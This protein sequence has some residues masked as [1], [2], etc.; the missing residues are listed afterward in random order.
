MSPATSLVQGT[1]GNFYGMTGGGG[2]FDAGTVFKITPTG[3]LTVLHGFA[4]GPT[5]GSDPTAALVQATDGNFY[6]TT[7]AG[8]PADKGTVFKMTPA[9]IVTI[10]HFFDGTDGASPQG[11]LIQATDGNF[12]GTTSVGGAFRLGTVFSM[13]PTGTLTVLHHFAGGTDGANPYGRLL[14]A[15]DG[16]LYGTTTRGGSFSLHGFDWG[17]IGTV[18]KVTPAGALTILHTFTDSVATVDSD[19][20][21]PNG[22]LIQAADGNF[23]GTTLQNTVF[24]MTPTGVLTTL[25]FFS[26]DSGLYAGVI[27]AADGNFYG[28]LAAGNFGMEPPLGSVFRMTSDGDV[29][30]LHAFAFATS[31]MEG[32]T[33]RAALIQ[34]ADGNFYGTTTSGGTADKGTIFSITPAGVLTVLQSLSGGTDG[35]SPQA[36]LIVATDG[37]FYG[38]TNQGG[39]SNSGTAFKMTPCGSLTVLHTFSSVTD[40]GRPAALIQGSDGNFYGTTASGGSAGNGT[41]FRMTAAG[42]VTV[43]HAFTGG[44]MDGAVP[45]AALIQ[46]RDGNFYGTTTSGGATDQG[47]VFRMTPAGTVTVLH[48]FIGGTAD[49]ASPLAALLQGADGN[50]YGTTFTGGTFNGGAV[51]KITPAGTITILHAFAIGTTD[52]WNPTA[53]LVQAT[54]GNFYGTT[55]SGGAA[56]QGTVFTM[57]PD[58]T[59][60]ILHSFAGSGGM[61]GSY[62]YGGLVQASDGNFYGTTTYGGVSDNGTI[63]K[64]TRGG[65]YS[66]LRFLDAGKMDGVN[67]LSALLQGVDGNLYGTASSG[68]AFGWGVVFRLVVPLPPSIRMNPAS[69]TVTLGQNPQFTVAANGTPA[70]TYQW[71]V[72]TTGGS[73]WANLSDAVPYSGVTTTTLT[74]T[75]ATLGLTGNQYR[76]VATNASG[77]ATSAVATLTV[78]PAARGDFDRDGKADIA[79]YRAASG[80]WY[81]LRS[82]SGYTAYG[83]QWGAST[84][85]PVPGDYDGDGETDIAI[86]RPATGIWYVLLSST[87]FAS[88]LAYQWGVSTD[89]PVPGDY[90]G[91]GK[92]DVAVYRPSTGTWYVLLSSTSSTTYVAYQWGVSTDVPVSADYDGD[93]KTDV[94]VYRPTTG[95]WY[96]LLSRTNAATY[97]AYQWGINSDIPVPADYD[98]DRKADIA[99]YRPATGIWYLLRSS[100]NSTT[101]VAYQ[102]GVSA[103]VPVPADF[104]GDGKTDIA[105]FRP[106][107]GFW[108]ILLSS[109]NSATYASYQWGAASDIPVLNRR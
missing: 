92:T 54:D 60:T 56:D 48:S 26:Q 71:Q 53:S 82:G 97:V 58:G 50:F 87:D 89:L 38:T 101:Y 2:A 40:G 64:T 42:T 109:T 100:T 16:N 25:H 3:T 21:I 12:Y 65:D 70:P 67:P 105:V 19:G 74:I 10:L 107:T 32:F 106:D 18:F 1:D 84:D 49:G 103:D 108:Y 63:F 47:T 99:V 86:Y 27:Q 37:N 98:G 72:S 102:W 31:S 80:V 36:A 17:D 7:T 14:Q 93:G 68:G 76:A 9:G 77:A 61:D 69:Q 91:D 22:D 52:G 81:V 66:I 75:R 13:T 57:T 29:T 39:T 90:D 33:P 88:S 6:G 45:Q 28:T 15:T 85:T 51:F 62:P 73:V 79:V 11:A 30:F 4:G 8:G 104:D 23:Y 24:R 96:V 43:L 46:G 20:S 95:V 35:A 34:A 83:Y 59:V 5:D 41:I 78:L 44:A 94:A 55:T